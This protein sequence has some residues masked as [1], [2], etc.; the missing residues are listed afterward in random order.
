MNYLQRTVTKPDVG[1]GL[2]EDWN[3]FVTVEGSILTAAKGDDIKTMFITS[4]HEGDGKSVTT[5]A[6]AMALTQG[7]INRVLLIDGNLARPRLHEMLHLDATPG[8]TDLL[9]GHAKVE[10]VIKMTAIPNLFCMPA[11]ETDV[12]PVSFFR[13]PFFAYMLDKLQKKF[14]YIIFDGPDYMGRSESPFLATVFD[15]VIL[16]VSYQDTRWKVAKIVKDRIHD[17]GGRV[18]GA[19]LNRRRYII[20]ESLYGAL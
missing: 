6:M 7:S 17:V 13:S 4:C 11:G 19:V 15:G 20:P 18:I 14:D 9:F 12:D 8:L 2:S 10:D 5:S 16:V 3:E 1:L